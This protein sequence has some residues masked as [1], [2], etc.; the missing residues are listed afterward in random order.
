MMLATLL[1]ALTAVTVATVDRAA[2]LDC[3][4]T[5]LEQSLEWATVAFIGEHVDERADGGQTF[6]VDRL[7]KGDV[8]GPEIEGLRDPDW[9]GSW[10]DRGQVVFLGGLDDDGLFRPDV[11][12]NGFHPLE[13]ILLLDGELTPPAGGTPAFVASVV[14]LPG[15][16]GAV[17]NELGEV[18]H[19]APGDGEI[20]QFAACPGDDIVA[21]LRSDARDPFESPAT[22]QAI[23]LRKS[24]DL[25]VI[26]AWAIDIAIRSDSGLPGLI[27]LECHT[28]DGSLVTAIAPS[29]FSGLRAGSGVPVAGDVLIVRDGT[30]EPH[31]VDWPRDA[32]YDLA[33][34]TLH[35]IAGE[36]G[37]TIT[38]ITSDGTT[39]SR[40]LPGT[41]VAW[42]MTVHDDWWHI[43]TEDIDI[44]SS[45]LR[46]GIVSHL[47]TGSFESLESQRLPLVTA[48]GTS[49]GLHETPN[50]RWLHLHDGTDFAVLVDLEDPNRAVTI[51]TRWFQSVAIGD[52]V[53]LTDRTQ[54][55]SFIAVLGVDG[56][57]AINGLI[58][59]DAIAA[60]RPGD[61]I[62]YDPPAG[63]ELPSPPATTT[64][65]GGG[66][67]AAGAYPTVA[68]DLGR[69]PDS[70]PGR[71]VTVA[72]PSA[73]PDPAP[74]T[75][76]GPTDASEAGSA[77]EGSDLDGD[78]GPPMGAIGA[79]VLVVLGVLL[80]AWRRRR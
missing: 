6:R 53:T 78:D 76:A 50:G 4:V 27:D 52:H 49:G 34:E 15:I 57:C 38:S 16:I 26:D 60:V 31:A 24:Q 68:P 30:I 10:L 79:I 33:T 39:T 70:C 75:T 51:G 23:E 22:P 69:A 54:T 80:L 35:L 55:S 19:Y 13:A 1:V 8:V 7:L 62:V 9:G 43:V 40:P 28:A 66:G 74:S 42:N 36:T 41:H 71:V 32:T 56:P 72:E 61:P 2:A 48:H 65:P 17:L 25:A 59:G 5:T 20:H 3:G 77:A 11:C 21:V 45:N 46:A 73:P 63:V 47:L 14:W 18:I 44:D 29:R 12:G 67:P 58:G 37:R 64:I